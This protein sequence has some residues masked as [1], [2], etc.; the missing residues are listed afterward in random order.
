MDVSSY[1][2]KKEGCSDSL[3]VVGEAG[4]GVLLP[5]LH[6]SVAPFDV[7]PELCPLTM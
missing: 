1:I 4:A 2:W 6:I 7:V 3:Q 5:V